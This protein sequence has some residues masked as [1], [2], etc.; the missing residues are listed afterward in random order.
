LPILL[1]VGLVYAL[2]MG[3][4]AAP[5]AADAPPVNTASPSVSPT[6]AYVGETLTLTQGG[7][8][9]TSGGIYDQWERCDLTCT[10]ITGATNTTYQV[11][12]SDVGD[13]LMVQET[14]EAGDGTPSTPASSNATSTVPAP[15][16]ND[17]APAI[18]GSPAP[19][20]GN[21]L[22]ATQGT[23]TNADSISDTW[24]DCNG[25][26]CTPIPGAT[27]TSYTLT[28]GD[29]G[30]TIEITETATDDGTPA[31]SPAVS[32]PTTVVQTPS[33]VSLTLAPSAPVANQSVTLA[34]TVTSQAAAGSPSGSM[35][36]FIN[37]RAI[38]GCGDQTVTPTGQSVTVLCSTSFGAQAGQLTA[39]F[40][41]AAGSL[42]LGSS[43]PATAL[44]VGQDATTTRLDASAQVAVRASTT[45]TATVIPVNSGSVA[46]SGVVE[47]LD[48]G[49][50]IGG[51]AAQ[52]VVGG[53]AACT[54]SYAATGSRSISAQYRGDANFSGSRSATQLVSVT[55]LPTKGS[56]TATMQWTFQ[57]APTYTRVI[58]MV[59]NGVPDGATVQVL[60]HGHG[61]PFAKRRQTMAKPRRC[62]RRRKSSCPVPGRINLTS[63]FRHK[64]SARA[65]ITI[66]IRRP[67]YIGKYYSFTFRPRKPPKVRIACLAVSGTKPDVG[68]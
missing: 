63:A 42:V 31:T 44:S 57:Y 61:C 4:F 15:P 1:S 51:C 45:Y 48:G 24:E 64:L 26:T 58:A 18:A 34:A 37:G 35:A 65:Q 23:W 22:T 8:S 3:P 49:Q 21:T 39:T 13:T 16:T 9:D 41:P 38:G 25:S 27:T 56:V 68:C 59:I 28:P 17:S 5:A 12:Y 36:F 47:F 32:Q 14:A 7:W 19:V 50:P 40:T 67:Q 6:T 66:E 29:V 55:T 54:V 10:A 60:C 62:T 2:S 30:Y 46:P 53:A 11:S 33:T 43:S 52:P 20:A